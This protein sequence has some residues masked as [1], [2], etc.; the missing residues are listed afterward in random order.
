MARGELKRRKD[1]SSIRERRDVGVCK[2]MGVENTRAQDYIRKDRQGRAR[3]VSR[4]GR[5]LLQQASALGR[6]I[7]AGKT[8]HV[9]LRR[10][11]TT[12]TTPQAASEHKGLSILGRR[13][14]AASGKG[15]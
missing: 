7:Q 3:P 2:G 10:P 1:N 9:A 4:A 11:A 5:T 12:K 8:G 6:Y 13:A 15:V 14:V